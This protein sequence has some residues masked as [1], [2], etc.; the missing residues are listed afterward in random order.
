VKPI[1]IIITTLAATAYKGE[2]DIESALNN[3]LIQMDTFVN[4]GSSIVLNPVNPEEN[5]ADRWSM[6]QYSHL[7]FREN[8]K[9]WVKQAQID[10]D[11]LGSTDD[12]RFITEQ[13][14]QKFSIKMNPSDLAKSLGLMQASISIISHKDHVISAPAKPHGI[15][16]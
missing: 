4:S 3:I 10:F 11:L 9:N 2:S 5:F 12:V 8:F 14:E 7:R 13:A 1:S 16:Y 15:L 6:P